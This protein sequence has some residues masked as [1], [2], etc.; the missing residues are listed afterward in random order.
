[1]AI[2]DST[3]SVISWRAM[4]PQDPRIK[5][6]YKRFQ[7]ERGK[8]S[9]D[10][11]DVRPMEDSLIIRSS[12][13]SAGTYT[14]G[15]SAGTAGEETAVDGA[16]AAQTASAAEESVE[17]SME[18]K[19]DIESKT[20]RVG[21]IKSGTMQL[22]GIGYRINDDWSLTPFISCLPADDPNSALPF[23]EKQLFGKNTN[24]PYASI[25]KYLTDNL[26]AMQGKLEFGGRTAL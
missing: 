12:T 2:G 21:E 3:R 17:V 5:E 19:V 14:A 16:A 24:D 11:A 15:K 25:M 18:V 8:T 23:F 22:Q 13:P 9:I 6:A 7:A 1:M 10:P 4:D 26:S 20:V